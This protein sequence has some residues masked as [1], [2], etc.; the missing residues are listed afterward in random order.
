VIGPSG[1]GKS[2]LLRAVTQSCGIYIWSEKGRRRMEYNPHEDAL[3][4]FVEVLWQGERMKLV[5]RFPTNEKLWEE[6][7][8]I[9]A[10]SL[11]QGGDGKEGTA[12][13]AKNQV[14]MDEGSQVAWPARHSK[15]EISAIQHAMNLKI[16]S[17]SAFWAEYQNEPLPEKNGIEDDELLTAE[18]IASKLN[19]YKRALVPIG[20]NHL[21]MFIDVQGK[22]LFWVVC[23]WQD[24]FTGYVLDYGAYP[25][26][27]R[28]YFTLR[29]AQRTL[30]SVVKGAGLEGGIFAGLDHL[31]NEHLAKEWHREDGAMMRVGLCLVDA[32][33]GTSTDMVYQFCRQSA[34][35]SQLM[36]SHG[37]FVGAGS[38]PFHEYTRRPGDRVGL[39]WRIPNVRGRRAIRHVLYDANYWKTFVHAR[40]SVPMGD[41]G[42]LSLFGREPKTHELLA[43]HLASEYRVKTE[44]RGRVVDEWKL[45]P[46]AR[47]NHWLDGVVGCAVAASALG[48]TLPGFAGE[49]ERKPKEKIRLSEIQGRRR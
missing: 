2:T 34:C 17:E 23:G 20:V 45:R 30:Q 38:K 25:D 16:R 8:R 35:A 28:P 6:Y 43:D 26:Q 31:A 49:R 9:Q 39:N 44:G 12:F 3:H 27:R 4:R 47:D 10:E 5:Y 32:N 7:A 46:E 14:A 13:Y 33:W 19:G 21:T 18:Q 36:P 48:A 40:L 24:D 22:L 37:R 41:K 29:D 11:R 1:S 42:C 15:G